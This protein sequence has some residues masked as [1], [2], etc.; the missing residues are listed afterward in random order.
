MDGGWRSVLEARGVEQVA[1]GLALV[2]AE[3]SGG[4]GGGDEQRR[5][6]RLRR[7]SE[8]WVLAI[9]R[10]PGHIEKIAGGGDAEADQLSA[11]RKIHQAVLVT[12]HFSVQES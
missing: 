7:W 5:G 11:M 8:Q 2:G 12:G 10:G 6:E 9:V 3:C 4:D 1:D